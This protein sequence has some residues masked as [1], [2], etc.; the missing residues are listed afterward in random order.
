[1]ILGALGIG[2]YMLLIEVTLKAEGNPAYSA[3]SHKVNFD[4]ASNRGA[5]KAVVAFLYLYVAS[6]AL[7]WATPAWVVPTMITRGRADSMTT[8]VNWFVNFW[9]ALYIPTALNNISWVLYIIFATICCAAA[10]ST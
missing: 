5:G 10:V 6:F 9:F 3:S 7:S 8:A 4:F 1:M 2:I